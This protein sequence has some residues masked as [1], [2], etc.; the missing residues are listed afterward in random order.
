MVAQNT[1]RDGKQKN[2]LKF[3]A[4]FDVKNCLKQIEYPVSSTR[5]HRF[6]SYNIT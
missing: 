4:A 6:L 1:L 2:Y 3:E 5:A